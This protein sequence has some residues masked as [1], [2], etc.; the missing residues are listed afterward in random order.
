MSAR[1]HFPGGKKELAV[2]ALHTSSAHMRDVLTAVVEAAPTPADSIRRVAQA[3]ADQLEESDFVS[4][5]PIA[6]V[7][8]ETSTLDEDI[9]GVCSDSYRQWKQLITDKL[10]DAGTAPDRVDPLASVVLSTMEGA[11]L[12]SRV[13]RDTTPLRTAGEELARLYETDRRSHSPT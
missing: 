7:A 2:E 10:A 11:L 6:T 1:P 5:C 8:L 3:L 13:H 9:R 12:L 4:G